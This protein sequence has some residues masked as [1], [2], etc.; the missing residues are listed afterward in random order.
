MP[1]A[2][3]VVSPCRV[4]DIRA[5]PDLLDAHGR[6]TEAA[7]VAVDWARYDM[8]EDAGVLLLLGVF[9]ANRLLGYSVCVIGAPMNHS[10]TMVAQ[11]EAIY[12]DKASR[13]LGLGLHLMR[14]TERDA[15]AAGCTT[16]LWNAK[17]GSSLASVLEGLGY[18]ADA[19]T[20][21]KEL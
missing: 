9:E 1:A 17:V 7:E 8:L 16:I 13:H 5:R 15:R 4:A 12:V 10:T 14:E 6:E 18:S 2:A 3:V 11:C 19:I 20:Y 21:R